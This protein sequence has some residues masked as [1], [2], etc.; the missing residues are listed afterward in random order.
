[1][2]METDERAD[3]GRADDRAPGR[4]PIRIDGVEAHASILTLAM[5]SSS[6]ARVRMAGRCLRMVTSEKR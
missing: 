1:M 3:L 6:N 4:Q 5:E 2:R